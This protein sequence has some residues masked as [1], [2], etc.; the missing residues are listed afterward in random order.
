MSYLYVT[1]QGAVIGIEQNRITVTYSENAKKSIPIE[2]LE[3]IA[4]LSKAQMTTAAVIECLKR[5]IPVSYYSAGG[6][7]FGRLH[8]TDFV[9]VE[10]QRKQDH[11]GD[12]E[13]FNLNLS[14]KFI[15]AKINNQIVVLRRYSRSTDVNIQDKIQKMLILKKRAQRCTFIEELMGCEGSAAR[16]YFEALECIVDP[17]FAFHGRSRRPPKDSFNSML[18]LGYSVLLNEIY[19]KIETKGLNPYFGFM[20]KDRE[21]HPTLASDL[22]EEWRAVLVDS[23]VLSLANG[24]EITPEE[25]I[26]DE[27][28]GG[29]Y[30]T[31]KGISIFIK[32]LEKKM[33]SEM[34]YL[35]YIDYS[36]S[37]RRALDLQVNQLWK[38]IEQKDPEK[39]QPVY[40]R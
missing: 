35:G 5:G 20:H 8:S 4:I 10:K 40:I 19:G 14:K 12:N 29:V 36:V 38:A 32:K 3:S 26:I 24:H 27:E 18:S 31:K 23:L 7:Y 2:T 28:S 37:F 21:N 25:F 13:E 33:K 17:V 1:E 16:N 9:N 11:I 30:L 39:Y 34:R 15:D 22:M 6:S